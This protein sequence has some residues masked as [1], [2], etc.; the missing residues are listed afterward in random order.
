MALR[1]DAPW[2]NIVMARDLAGIDACPTKICIAFG[3][4]FEK[5]ITSLL[6]GLRRVTAPA[7]TSGKE[8]ED[9]IA[10]QI[11]AALES[12][13]LDPNKNSPG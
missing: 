1:A 8:E 5:E 10:A 11:Q 13:R 12:L 4:K 9:R 3:D 7:P 6:Q 2:P